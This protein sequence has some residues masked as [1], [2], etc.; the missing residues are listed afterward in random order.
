MF[1]GKNSTCICWDCI[2]AYAHKCKKFSSR[3]V[4][5]IWE[6]FYLVTRPEYNKSKISKPCYHIVKCRKFVRDTRKS[7]GD[8]NEC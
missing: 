5:D 6:D 3:E 2:Y 8:D 1:R 4:L 7:V